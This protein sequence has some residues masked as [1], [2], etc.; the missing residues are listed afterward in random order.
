MR[1]AKPM[2]ARSRIMSDSP[3]SP[4]DSASCCGDDHGDH[5]APAASKVDRTSAYCCPMC[6]GVESDRP[7][8]C[9]KCGMSL[10]RNP[11]FQA[12]ARTIYTCP[13]HPEIEQDHPGHCSICGM[14]LE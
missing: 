4:P 6:A 10:E 5:V 12:P 8:S 3:L 7:G 1:A 13:M 9:P 2:I 14:A 11:A